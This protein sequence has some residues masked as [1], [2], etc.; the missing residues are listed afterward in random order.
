M[1][2]GNVTKQILQRAELASQLVGNIRPHKD[3]QDF[4]V[5]LQVML[6]L[7]EIVGIAQDRISRSEAALDRSSGRPVQLAGQTSILLPGE[8]FEA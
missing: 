6:L 3:G 1:A 7:E 2:R 5:V 8:V 4:A